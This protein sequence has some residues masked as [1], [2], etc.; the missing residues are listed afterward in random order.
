MSALAGTVEEV[1]HAEIALRRTESNTPKPGSGERRQGSDLT[2]GNVVPVVMR[3][4]RVV[5]VCTRAPDAV[6]ASM[7]SLSQTVI[8]L[9]MEDR[10]RIVQVL[11]KLLSNA[12]R[13]STETSV[14]RVTSGLEELHFGF[15]VIYEGRGV[16][17]VSLPYL[18]RKFSR[19]Q[20]KEQGGDMGLGLAICKGIVEAHGGESVPRATGRDSA[21]AFPSPCSSWEESRAEWRIPTRRYRLAPCG[22]DGERRE[23][24][25]GCW[26][27]TMTPGNF[28]TFRTPSLRRATRW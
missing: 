17:A 15:S 23:N 14:I 27:W 12:A 25:C 18:I 26:R 6:G 19:V 4:G 2:L 1:R 28:V 16:L 21:P 24:G 10:R 3:I 20:S 5:A 22:A 7:S 13:D 11:G 8:E 9:A